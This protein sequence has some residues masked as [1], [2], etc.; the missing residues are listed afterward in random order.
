MLN[1]LFHKFNEF[2]GDKQIR[3][4]PLAL[5]RYRVHFWTCSISTSSRSR[6]IFIG[7]GLL[8]NKGE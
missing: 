1:K 2:R 3:G 4:N 8:Y 5:M 7:A 6:I